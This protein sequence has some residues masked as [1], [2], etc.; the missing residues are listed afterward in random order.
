MRGLHGGEIAAPCGD[1][2]IAIGTVQDAVIGAAPS[3]S[4]LFAAL[5]P[6]NEDVPGITTVDHGAT[7]AF[8]NGTSMASPH[9]AG[10]AALIREQHPS[11]SPGA[12]AAALYNKATPLACPPDW[13]PLSPHDER[14]RCYGSASHTSFFGHGLVDASAATRH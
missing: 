13:Q 8:L 6:L 4:V 11:W 14:T 2:F 7:C 1:Y 3:D 9:A 12:V 10:V 5:D